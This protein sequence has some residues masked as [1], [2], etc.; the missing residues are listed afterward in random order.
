MSRLL[1]VSPTTCLILHEK[2]HEVILG[3]QK[4]L[5]ADQ[6]VRW[7]RWCIA[8]WGLSAPTSGTSLGDV[9]DWIL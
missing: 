1:A 9:E 5:E 8:T 2:A 4:L 6:R 7:W 3:H